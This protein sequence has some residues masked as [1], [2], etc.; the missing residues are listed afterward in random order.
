MLLHWSF[1]NWFGM[2][3]LQAV[4]RVTKTP[5]RHLPDTFQTPSRHLS[6]TF[7]TPPNLLMLALWRAL[8]GK[9]VFKYNDI[10]GFFS[11]I[12]PS[13]Q[14]R[15]YPES[16]RQHPETPQT[17]SRQYP[18]TSVFSMSVKPYKTVCYPIKSVQMFLEVSSLCPWHCLGWG[19]GEVWCEING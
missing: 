10:K 12:M 17:L 15:Q 9:T 2:I 1:I 13:I 18:I 4:Y 16:I 3:T 14:Y 7:Q 5:S 6:D 19:W 8:L 11:T